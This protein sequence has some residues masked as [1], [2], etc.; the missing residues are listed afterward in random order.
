MQPSIWKGLLKCRGTTWRTHQSCRRPRRT[1]GRR[2]L[3]L[4][5][6][7]VWHRHSA[8]CCSW[9]ALPLRN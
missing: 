5:G 3:R 7:H 2:K 1:F 4:H 8:S 9:Y 6:W